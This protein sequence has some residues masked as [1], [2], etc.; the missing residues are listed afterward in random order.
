[1]GL[2]NW[3]ADRISTVLQALNAVQT[4]LGNKTDAAL[5]LDH[6]TLMFRVDRLDPGTGA[7]VTVGVNEIVVNSMHAGTLQVVD[8]LHEIGHIVDWHISNETG[9]WSD[10][11]FIPGQYTRDRLLGFLWGVGERKYRGERPGEFAPHSTANPVEDFADT[12]SW[13]VMTDAGIA[14]PGG[15]NDPASPGRQNDLNRGLDSL[16]VQANP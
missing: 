6:G 11:N 10:K 16:T 9:L 7:Q 14:L 12:F 8:Y 13:R 15:W 4:S 1:M 5:G 2:P 3:Q